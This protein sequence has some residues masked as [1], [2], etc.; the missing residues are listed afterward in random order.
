MLEKAFKLSVRNEDSTIGSIE[1]AILQKPV[2]QT[3]KASRLFH[4]EVVV[5]VFHDFIEQSHKYFAE[6]QKD[7]QK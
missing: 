3:T 6:V 1:D 2:A 4:S 7:A 5:I